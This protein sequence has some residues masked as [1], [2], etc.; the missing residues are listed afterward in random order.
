MKNL[1]IK[2]K[3]IIFKNK[4]TIAINSNYIFDF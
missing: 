3:N 1:Y 2:A 4:I